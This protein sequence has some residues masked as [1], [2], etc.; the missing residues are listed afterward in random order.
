MPTLED[1]KQ[2][3]GNSVSLQMKSFWF[4]SFLTVQKLFPPGP[5]ASSW[6]HSFPSPPA[7]TGSSFSL[8]PPQQFGLLSAWEEK[9]SLP[10]FIVPPTVQL[11]PFY[12][13]QKN[14]QVLLTNFE[15]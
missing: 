1:T 5:S 7:N 14:L 12:V 2:G 4:R 15:I 11:R 6:Q 10:L 8:A 9:N 3:D 13:K